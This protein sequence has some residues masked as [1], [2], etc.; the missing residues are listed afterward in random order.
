MNIIYMSIV[1]L[2]LGLEMP[3][4]S[5]SLY[6]NTKYTE[7]NITEPFL[8]TKLL[9]IILYMIY[10]EVHRVVGQLFHITGF[11]IEK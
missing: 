8:N 5:E 3:C 4:K 2:I 1:S 10:F 11:M 7:R 9:K 6:P